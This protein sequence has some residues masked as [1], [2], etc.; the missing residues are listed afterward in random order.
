MNEMTLQNDES[1]VA[2]PTQSRL[3][4]TP[5]FDVYEG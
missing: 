2:T 5:R 1:N 3:W 4:F